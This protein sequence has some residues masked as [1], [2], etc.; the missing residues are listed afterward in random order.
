MFVEDLNVVIAGSAGEGIQTIG[1]ILA[2]T[3][4]L[5]GYSVFTWNEYESRIGGGQNSYSIRVG[6]EPKRR[7]DDEKIDA[8]GKQFTCGD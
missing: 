5:Q 2:K 3:L 1:D 4:A 7:K 8:L 6:D